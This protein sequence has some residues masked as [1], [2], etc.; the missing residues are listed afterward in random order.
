MN[1]YILLYD[2]F[3]M[4]EGFD[5]GREFATVHWADELDS[6]SEGH[7]VWKN[8]RRTRSNKQG[9]GKYKS[10][11]KETAGVTTE[12]WQNL[13]PAL[14]T[15]IGHSQ[16]GDH[17]LSSQVT[18]D[19][20]HNHQSTVTA[21][22][23]NHMLETWSKKGVEL[24]GNTQKAFILCNRK[25]YRQGM[26]V[27]C[28]PEKSKDWHY[29]IYEFDPPPTQ[30]TDAIYS[31]FR[32]QFNHPPDAI[33]HV[34]N[35]TS[36]LPSQA[37]TLYQRH[38]FHAMHGSPQAEELHAEYLAI[39]KKAKLESTMKPTRPEE[40][41]KPPKL[42]KVQYGGDIP[43]LPPMPQ[44]LIPTMYPQKGEGEGGGGGIGDFFTN[45]LS[46]LF[47]PEDIIDSIFSIAAL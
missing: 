21:D 47:N 28:K 29:I 23:T 44:P 15:H 43:A 11:V 5:P 24:N 26:V 16:D 9:G 27:S 7:A 33:Y 34:P 35:E 20:E 40:T 25:G 30:T 8:T 42:K 45:T 17:K 1:T 41:P 31:A 6:D 3:S 32:N 18:L 37:H 12:D 22:M 2:Y 19:C 10:L 39:A 4:A 38:Q 13:N 36:N 14:K 46:E